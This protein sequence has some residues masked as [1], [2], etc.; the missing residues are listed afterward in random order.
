MRWGKSKRERRAKGAPMAFLITGAI[1][2]ILLGLRFKVFVLVPAILLATAVIII[3]GS[4]HTLSVMVLTVFGTVVSLQIGYIVGCILRAW[5]RAY[6]AAR[7]TLRP[8]APG[9]VP[10]PD[11]AG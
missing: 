5:A 8:H 11:P 9:G 3:S 4:D 7:R 10:G 1:T 6:L 2:G